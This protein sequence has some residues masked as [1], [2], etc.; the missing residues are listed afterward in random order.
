MSIPLDYETLRLI[1]WLL[2]G[3]LLIGFA[4]FGG[5]DLGVGALLPF[6]ARTDDERRLL[7]NLI[8]PTW[9]GNQVWLVLGGGAIFAAW[10]ALY[11]VSF[12]GFY[13]AM[14]AI[15]LALI[16]RPVG[17][18]FRGKVADPTWRSIWDWALFIGG[19]VPALIFGV[20][21]GNVLR[22]VPFTFDD[23]L[24]PIYTGTFFGLLNPFSLVCGLISLGMLVVHGAVVIAA[25]VSG[26][27]A[28][29]A[30]AYGKIAALLVI[31][32]FALA[33]VWVAYG[34]DGYVVTS[35]QAVDG[36]SNPLGKTAVAQAGAWLA[37][38]HSHG[39]M[40]IAP[41]LGFLGAI[42][43]WVGLGQKGMKL[44]LLGS[45]LSIFG[46][47]S[48]AGLSLFPFLLPSSLDPKSSL[49][50]WDTSSS[51]LTLWIMLIATCIFLPI[52]LAYTAVVYRVMRGPV[53][54]AS[55]SRNP[56]AY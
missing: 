5:L 23:T 41:V 32:L 39:W 53:N 18:K 33:G 21:V 35:V 27:V 4:L 16:L 8:G 49:T 3:I 42:I 34:L 1:W 24:R 38:Y 47:I 10:P 7:L 31:V 29:R 11:A 46:I 20:A 9:E 37:N 50:V 43:A 12:S 14:I 52:V 28:D 15:L 45:S 54:A 51:H 19:F 17:F 26:P 55:I 36:P 22:G 30:R 6:A 48:T 56:N 44:A 25:R 2:L 40:L 13:L